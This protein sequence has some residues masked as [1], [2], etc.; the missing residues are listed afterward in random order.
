MDVNTHQVVTAVVVGLVVGLMGM[1][2]TGTKGRAS[3]REWM[4]AVVGV[5]TAFIGTGLALALPAVTTFLGT[6]LTRLFDLHRPVDVDNYGVLAVQV[7][8]AAAGVALMVGVHR[9]RA[10]NSRT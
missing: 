4:I 10:R 7:V 1:M 6:G 5:A 3:A 2:T 9:R 8:L